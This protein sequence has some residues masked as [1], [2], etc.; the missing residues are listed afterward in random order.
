MNL[1]SHIEAVA[2]NDKE[3]IAV[4]TESNKISYMEL[5]V[6]SCKVS[7][8]LC[9]HGIKRGD[10]VAIML[11]NGIEF[12]EIY[13]GILK[14][15]AIVVSLNPCLT[16]CEL[17]DIL[18]D[19]NASFLFISDDSNSIDPSGERNSSALKLEVHVRLVTNGYSV[20]SELQLNTSEMSDI[21]KTTEMASDEPAVIVYTSGTMG[22][23]KGVT[24]SHRNILLNI[25]AKKKLLK[26][27]STDRLIL[28]LPLFHCFGQNAIMNS[29]FAVGA[30][31]ILHRFFSPSVIIDS[32]KRDRVT[33][34]FATP[35]IYRIICSVASKDDFG[36]LKFFFSAAAPLS[37][38]LEDAWYCKF[39][40]HIYQGYGLT[41]TSPF[42]SYNHFSHYKKSSIGTPIDGVEMKIVDMYNGT[43]LPSGGLG[44][45]CIRG[46]NVMLGYWENY[47]ATKEVI[48]NGWLHTGDIGKM[49]QDGYFYYIDRLKDMIIIDGLKVYP[50]EVE[51]AILSHPKVFDVA[52][53]GVPDHWLG[54]K[55]HASVILEDGLH[56]SVSDLLS[57]LRIRIA[58][59]KLPLHI[60]FVPTLPKTPS[61]KVLKRELR[62]NYLTA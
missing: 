57:Y 5:N 9:K 2:N 18:H 35:T 46:H 6:R 22:R 24:L 50:A 21:F 29:A 33:R 53:Y 13:M 3:A 17:Q 23:M 19:C 62:N 60:D 38:E 41:E 39:G 26:L 15:G 45:I 52:V 44:E 49:D 61:G 31:L 48:R 59:Y 20:D 58:N 11:P 51:L 34:F 40:Y 37:L 14:V 30:T 4:E 28:F 47:D 27:D 36:D 8:W 1:V 12:I 25:N 32:I 42:S 54:E 56:L 16:K 55:V 10:R 7:N 43:D